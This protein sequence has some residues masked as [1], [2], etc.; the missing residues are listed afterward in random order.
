MKLFNKYFVFAFL[1]Y[2]LWAW[3]L[4]AYLNIR[5]D[6]LFGALAMG[7]AILMF[8][9]KV[10]K[11]KPIVFPN[12]LVFLF[13]FYLYSLF[14]NTLSDSIEVS[15]KGPIDFIFLNEHLTPVFL[16]FIVENIEI[17]P[18]IF[19]YVKPIAL[20]IFIVS[21]VV[22]VIQYYVPFFGMYMTFVTQTEYLDFSK[23]LFSIYSWI[24]TNAV[25][26]SFPFIAAYLYMNYRNELMKFMIA[27][28]ALLYAFFT[29]T[30]YIILSMVLILSFLY[31][32]E[33]KL[34]LKRVFVVLL[35][36][37]I[38]YVFLTIFSFDVMEFFYRRVLEDDHT[39]FETSSAGSRVS[40]FNAFINI[41]PEQP[42]F[43]N[44]EK[45]TP[46]LR[47]LIGEDPFIHIGYL[48]Y[49]YAFGL[50]GCFFFFSF[51]YTFLRRIQKM[52]KATKDYSCF[53]A[54]IG[55]LLANWTLVWFRFF[56]FGLFICFLSLVTKYKS[57][58]QAKYNAVTYRDY[59][60]L[61]GQYQDNKLISSFPTKF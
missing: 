44:G 42:I 40:G 46:A 35:I 19:R 3:L 6:Y 11:N 10:S 53:I 48:H 57:L 28:G 50:L 16:L 37:V 49:L 56:D 60:I 39:N 7:Y 38:F 30:R 29:Q 18:A 41:F 17:E 25:G 59:Q 36:P 52:S 8:V 14:I 21:V 9:T 33:K 12:Y 27:M 15:H 31:F 23:R 22:I 2:P 54:L 13:L 34:T 1:L 26:I 58:V 20:L 4:M 32:K 5:I 43:G 24:S 51:C 61:P 55:F 47:K 45:V